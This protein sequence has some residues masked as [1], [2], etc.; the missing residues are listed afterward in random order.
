MTISPPVQL[1]SGEMGLR[2][3]DHI[4]AMIAYWDDQQVC[5][6]ANNAYME[7]FGRSKEEMIDRI[8]MKELL[9]PLYEKNLPYIK[10]ALAGKKQ[11]FER[12]ITLVDGSIRHSLATYTPDIVEGRVNGF[13][14]HVAD[15]SYI[16]HLEAKLLRTKQDI[17]RN[18]IETQEKERMNIEHILNENVNQMLVY[19][20]MLLSHDRSKNDPQMN[21]KILNSINQAIDELKALS[22]NLSPTAIKHFGFI[23]G[24]EDYIEHLR[25]EHPIKFFFEYNESDIESLDLEDKLS[26]FRIIQNFILLLIHEPEVK[27]IGIILHFE[28]PLLSLRLSHDL[29]NYSMPVS[30]KEYSN[31][32][33]RLEYYGGRIKS[34]ETGDQSNLLIDLN[35][36]NTLHP[37]GKNA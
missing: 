6:F 12:E 34:F 25:T 15:I 7:W 23:S 22:F 37:A 36:N 31:I 18:V 35:I 2:V 21:D 27:N 13:F 28:H 10:Q 24:T 29:K 9:G 11:V 19:S 32:E 1:T 33:Q 30:S 26:I 4:S 3:C 16:K 14:V 20:K 5:R 8:T 17:L